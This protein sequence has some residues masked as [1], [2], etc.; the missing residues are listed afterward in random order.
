[1]KALDLQT[2]AYIAITMKTSVEKGWSSFSE[3][4]ALVQ[5]WIDAKGNEIEDFFSSGDVK[6][7]TLR[8]TDS[9]V[10]NTLQ[11]QAKEAFEY[12]FP[13]RKSIRETI[14]ARRKELGYTQKEVAEKIDV[15]IATIGD[16][17]NGKAGL[18]SDKL[19]LILSFLNLTI[20]KCTDAD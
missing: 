3:G 16:F 2:I 20:S 14:A 12:F 9:R 10:Y 19:E 11:K 6:K 17:E 8:N 15:R 5:S 1:M 7:D 4:K 18:G 13:E